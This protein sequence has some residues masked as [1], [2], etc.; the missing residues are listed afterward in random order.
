MAEKSKK[1]QTLSEAK[2]LL[3]AR[4]TKARGEA[5]LR[6]PKPS[7]AWMGGAAG[8]LVCVERTLLSAASDSCPE[9]R[10]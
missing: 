2:D 7:K 1:S 10:E 8:G 3:L 4:L 5:A 6:S 9:K